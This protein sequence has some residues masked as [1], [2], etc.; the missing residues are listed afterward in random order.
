MAA[1]PLTYEYLLL[2]NTE[3]ASKSLQDISI[4]FDQ[5]AARG[6]EAFKRVGGSAQVSGFQIGAISGVVQTVT[7][8]LLNMAAQ[9][10]Q[11]LVKLGQESMQLAAQ[12]DAARRMFSNIFEGNEQVASAVMDRV[13]SK[14]AALGIEM[15]DALSLGRAFLPDVQNLE[16]FDKLLG[17]MRGMA[18]ID[19]IQ[20][21]AGARFA[22]DE[23]MSGQFRSLIGRFEFRRD[24][25]DRIKELQ[26]ELGPVAG[27]IEGVTKELER[28]G[29][30]TEMLGGTFQTSMGQATAAI[31]KV[32][33]AMGR[34]LM[35]EAMEGL[36]EFSQVMG[37]KS[38][39]FQLIAGVVGD[40]LAS[41][42]DFVAGGA[43]D[44]LKNLD[45]DKVMEVVQ[46]IQMMAENARTLAEILLDMDFS[47][48][49]LDNL[50]GATDK[51]NEA[52]ET[53]IKLAALAKAEAARQQ[54]EA[55]VRR[56]AAGAEGE[57]YGRGRFFAGLVGGT[58]QEG[59]EERARA[60]GEKAFGDVMLET[61]KALDKHNQRIEENKR[62][63]EERRA[64]LEKQKDTTDEL[65]EA[66]AQMEKRYA[67]IFG[68]GGTEP[69]EETAK[70][71]EKV[72]K[73]TE[74]IEIQHQRRMAE[75]DKDALRDRLAAEQGFAE[76]RLDLARKNA[77][78]VEDIN[79]DHQDRLDDAA[80]DLSRDEEKIARDMARKRVEAER[81]AAKE[82]V[83]IEQDLVDELERIRRRFN[84]DLLDA[85]R[86]QDAIAFI[87]AIRARDREIEEARIGRDEKVEEARAEAEEK[88]EELKLQQ[89]QEVEDAK[90][91][92][93]EK[94]EDL[95]LRLNRELE[96][97]ATAY[98]RDLEQQGITEDRKRAQLN[99]KYLERKADEDQRW[100]EAYED[101]NRRMEEEFAL[102]EAWEQKKTEMM[103]AAEEARQA[104]LV[105]V[106]AKYNQFGDS[107][108]G[109]QMAEAQDEANQARE[110]VDSI[111]GGQVREAEE[112]RQHVDSIY[113]EQ[114]RNPAN[115]SSGGQ[116]RTAAQRAASR[117]SA[118]APAPRPTSSLA[119][120]WGG[121]ASA[122]NNARGSYGQR[123]QH[124]GPV[125]GG[126]W[127]V[128]E[129]GPEILQIPS[130]TEGWVVPNS[131]LMYSPRFGG[132]G[133]STTN[134]NQRTVIMNVD[135]GV[136]SDAQ[137]MQT[138]QLI[139]QVLDEVES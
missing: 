138:R 6:D 84:E 130:G 120:F 51:L 69:D 126:E 102:I 125:W 95:Q 87:E 37:E 50:T 132:A 117:T 71:I 60:A 72:N 46:G 63:L 68:A 66:N 129:A 75:I 93:E 55:E 67:K 40:T 58:G 45:V 47:D 121:I 42:V 9:G 10:T 18:E 15:N 21:I 70:A 27:T 76:D 57:T 39:D 62:K 101:L 106:R 110:H 100:S 92:N 136:L 122:F 107:I 25:V 74:D 48:S 56:A 26:K 115:F 1:T 124:G 38:Q 80:I 105:E 77:Q 85:E 89:E 16:Q 33:L 64:E 53:A 30:N 24:Q 112:A 96:K 65:A 11:A 31:D 14:A 41:I 5:L 114:M 20:G 119:S 29:V 94:L 118:T 86:N 52:L 22:I 137:I 35:E 135:P 109:S 91:A 113:G 81:E 34:P 43:I 7:Q 99:D 12:F 49:F 73:A 88:R 4:K 127:L 104:R 134:S 108:Y 61:V 139:Y 83:K 44:F 103:V 36:D 19:P 59:V 82:Q 8:A 3:S 128:G 131:Q 133:S 23:A 28:M 98:E 97:Q 54:A 78:R 79:S 13:I 2:L 111:Y 32:K 17:M 116:G 90:I 123:R